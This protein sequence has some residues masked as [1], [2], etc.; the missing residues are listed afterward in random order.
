MQLHCVAPALSNDRSSRSF[1][2]G[3]VV[4]IVSV[5]DEGDFAVGL[6][7]RPF[8]VYKETLAVF[9]SLQDIAS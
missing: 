9:A 2:V 6:G 3:D 4:E 7:L 5:D 8:W 1:Q